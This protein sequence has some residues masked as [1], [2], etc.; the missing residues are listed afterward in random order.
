MPGGFMQSMYVVRNTS[1]GLKS[2]LRAD[3]NS[4]QVPKRKPK[5]I[6]NAVEEARPTPPPKK[7][8]AFSGHDSRAIELAYQKLA[9]D[10]H[11]SR[12][13]IGQEGADASTG[14]SNNGSKTS[15]GNTSQG[16]HQGTRVPVHEDFLFDV[17]IEK[18][19]L[20]PVYW[21]GPI[22]QVTRGTWFYDDGKAC[23]ESLAA[24]LEQGYL[25]IKPFRYPSP[26]PKSKQP[27]RA[28][29]E[30]KSLAKSGAFGRARTGSGDSTPRG[31]VD[32]QRPQVLSAEE[33]I[34]KTHRL[35]GTYM[36]SVVTYQDSTIACTLEL[37]LQPISC[38]S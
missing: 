25:K 2:P 9:D 8:V 4:T 35:F 7:F 37:P 18:R 15:P 12:A 24:Q 20:A 33:E 1:Y 27:F 34:Q 36:N 38:I 6:S 28:A 32:G 30:Q 13:S 10:Y 26:P 31:S 17:D 21:L 11:N 5:L 19:E 14:T 29:E 3:S 22:F 16:E 23:D